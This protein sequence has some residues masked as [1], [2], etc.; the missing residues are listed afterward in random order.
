MEHVALKIFALNAPHNP[1]ADIPM[2]MQEGWSMIG[3]TCM[4]SVNVEE[5]F[6]SITDQI[7]IIKDGAGNPYLP[8]YGY[9]G[10]GELHYSYG[11]QMKLKTD[12]P[13]F[14]MC[15]APSSQNVDD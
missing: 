5:A 11:Y 7:I 8:E 1:L 12:I 9:N 2:Q 3:Y 13:D 14:Y 15:P 6:S 4:Q 10:L